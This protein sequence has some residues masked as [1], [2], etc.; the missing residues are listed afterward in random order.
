DKV[1]KMAKSLRILVVD[2]DENIRIVFKMN[3]ENRGY[4]VDS[5]ANGQEALDKASRRFYNIALID[6]KLPDMEGTALLN[7]LNEKLPK[8]K[9]IIVTGFPTIENAMKAVNEGADGYILKPVKM[10]ALI[11]II[12]EHLRKQREEEKY[13]ERKVEEFIEARA[14]E[15]DTMTKYHRPI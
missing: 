5:A 6:I 12:E 10:E 2:D 7:T 15:L 9:K 8:M 4:Q 13:S 14:R 3:L 11:E 1:V